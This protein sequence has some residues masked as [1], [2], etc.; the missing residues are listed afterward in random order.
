MSKTGDEYRKYLKTNLISSK[1]LYHIKYLEQKVQQ[2]KVL[3]EDKKIFIKECNVLRIRS[4]KLE[5]QNKEILDMLISA[6]IDENWSGDQ[7]YELIEKIKGKP[8]E[9]VLNENN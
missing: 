1:V 6:C 5:Q 9:E 2:N 3:E 4:I 8:I 7:A